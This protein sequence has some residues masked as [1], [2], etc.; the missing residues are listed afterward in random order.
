MPGHSLLVILGFSLVLGACMPLKTD[1][2]SKP[3]ANPPAALP[4]AES[5]TSL[6]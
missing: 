2:P 6:P 5:P 4:S 3:S 1:L